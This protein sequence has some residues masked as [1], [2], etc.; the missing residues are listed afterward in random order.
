MVKTMNHGQHAKKGMPSWLSTLLGILVLVVCVFGLAAL[1][2]LFV[3]VPYE[4]PSGSMESTIKVGDMVFSEKVSYY[5]R[6]PQRGDIVTFA[7][8]DTRYPG[9]ILIKRVIATEGQTVDVRD[10]LVYVDG[11]ALVEPYTNGKPS[12][13]ISPLHGW[14]AI[15]YPYTVPS[16]CVWVMGD[17]RTSS[18]DSRAFGA[19]S[20]DTVTGRAAFVYWPIADFGA[21][22]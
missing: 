14:N 6:E 3:F 5:F 10:G 2:R 20:V 9:R 17:N 19:I 8:P 13:P 11:V 21:L 15:V 22:S 4:I 12:Y 1:M 18:Q 7:D 16:G